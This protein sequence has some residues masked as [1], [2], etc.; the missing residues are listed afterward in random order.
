MLQRIRVDGEPVK[1]GI[2]IVLEL[3]DEEFVE[4]FL[5]RARALRQVTPQSSQVACSG[6]M[7][8]TVIPSSEGLVL[9]SSSRYHQRL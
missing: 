4:K 3:A 5:T 8:R 9:A 6:D 2:S 7:L 1:A